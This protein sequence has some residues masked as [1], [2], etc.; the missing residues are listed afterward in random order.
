[1]KPGPNMRGVE[2]MLNPNGD[3]DPVADGHAVLEIRGLKKHF[4]D[5]R[6]E[7]RVLEGIDLAV[8]GGEIV[9]VIGRSGA[10]KTTLISLMAGL[11]RPSSGSVMLDGRPLE[12]LSNEELTLL[13]RQKIG[14]VFQSFNLLPSMTAA[15]NVEAALLPTPMPKGDRREKVKSLL[16]GLG[17]GDRADRFP[18]QLSVGE[19]Q[20]V[21]VARALVN[22]PVLILADEPT[23]DVDNETAGEIID[24]L[25]APVRRAN[26]TLVVTT[27]GCFPDHVAG[28]SLHLRCG[29]LS[30]QAPSRGR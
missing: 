12:D 25:V 27:H 16:V 3:T 24:L 1:M 20:R 7:V 18:S 21:A 30:S 4:Q 29:K 9:V 13:R 22:N 10:G 15:E 17:L 14:I 8:R 28:R 11:D 23:G 19:Q 6:R 2:D 26:A 5:G